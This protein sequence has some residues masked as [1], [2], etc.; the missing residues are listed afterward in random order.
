VTGPVPEPAHPDG[1]RQDDAVPAVEQ[2]AA[3]LE[4]LDDRPVSERVAVLDEVHRR[5]QDALAAVDGTPEGGA[6]GPPPARG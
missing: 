3:L 6:A 2:A 4:G 1:E 5:L